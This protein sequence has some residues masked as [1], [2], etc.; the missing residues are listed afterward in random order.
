[1]EGEP[2]IHRLMFLVIQI[3][4]LAKTRLGSITAD[5]PDFVLFL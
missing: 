1:V 4:A 3:S 2:S 5:L